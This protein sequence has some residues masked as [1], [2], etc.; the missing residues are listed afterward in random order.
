MVAQGGF[1]YT[2]NPPTP[3]HWNSFRVG[4]ATQSLMRMEIQFLPSKEEPRTRYQPS[5]LLDGVQTP[6]DQLLSCSWPSSAPDR[7]DHFSVRWAGFWKP[8]TGKREIRLRASHHA[9]LSMDGQPLLECQECPAGVTAAIELDARIHPL[10]IDYSH[11]DGPAYVFLDAREP[12]RAWYPV[13]VQS[14][15]RNETTL[16]WKAEY[17][18][19]ENFEKLAFAETV[20]QIVF[21]WKNGG[22]FDRPEDLP[23]LTF[24]WGHREDAFYGE[25]T[26][27]RKG[28]LWFLPST[29]SQPSPGGMA[30]KGTNTSWELHASDGQEFL[31]VLFDEGG[32]WLSQGKEADH[33]ESSSLP[34]HSVA[35]GIGFLVPVRPGRPIRFW[36]DT[37]G[38]EGGTWVTKTLDTNG[39]DFERSRPRLEGDF[40]SGD[41]ALYIGGRWWARVYQEALRSSGQES[42]ETQPGSSPTRRRLLTSLVPEIPAAV[43]AMVSLCMPGLATSTQDLT[44]ER[45]TAALAGFLQTEATG[46]LE[47]LSGVLEELRSPGGKP[48]H[49]STSGVASE[50]WPITGLSRGLGNAL[51]SYSELKSVLEVGEDGAFRILP[52][53]LI[54]RTL[55]IENW[56]NTDGTGLDLTVSPMGIRIEQRKGAYLQFDQPVVINGFHVG[57]KGEWLAE[58]QVEGKVNLEAGPAKTLKGAVWN[59]NPL[60]MT[61]REERYL[62]GTLPEGKGELRIEWLAHETTIPRF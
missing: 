1:S 41:V 14:D 49:I 9:A 4:D 58:V 3:G 15:R 62:Q 37:P 53:S 45:K 33:L 20:P 34:A 24:R 35:D 13:E 56:I 55:K 51:R 23:T 40:A 6:G 25:V 28:Y 50:R 11:C 22:P 57:K 44:P 54:Q 52:K 30:L 12:R 19:G 16:G 27:N 32:T 18:L 39:K 60:L 48:K 5:G 21:D 17:Y 31:R 7:D 61:K 38:I 47:F 2:L 8:D 46:D 42:A 43:S 29:G 26:S 36:E 10:Q 59:R